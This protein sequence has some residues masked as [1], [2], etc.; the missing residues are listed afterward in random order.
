VK[1]KGN[2]ARDVLT[3]LKQGDVVGILPDQNSGDVFAP[4]F[5]V[6][7]GTAAGPALFALRTGAPIIPSYTVRQP[8]DTYLARFFPPIEIK[9]TGDRSADA[10]QI[11]T[12]ANRIL[13]QVVRQYPEQWLWLHNRWKSAFEKKNAARAWPDGI[14]TPQYHEVLSRWKYLPD[15][16]EK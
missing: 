16:A 9:P 15:S 4:F 2:A 7:A 11:M 1:D 5:G 12:E 13:E 6:P 10:Q 8:D 14:D 3:A